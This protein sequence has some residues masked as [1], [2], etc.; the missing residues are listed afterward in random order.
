MCHL[1]FCE[2]EIEVKNIVENINKQVLYYLEWNESF[3][4]CVLVCWAGGL[5]GGL[6]G[7]QAGKQAGRLAGW[8]AGSPL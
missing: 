6:A 5:A 8:L 2:E 3:L 4:H 7:R 1:S